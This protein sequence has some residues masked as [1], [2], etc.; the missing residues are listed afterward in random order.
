MRWLLAFALRLF[1][2]ALLIGVPASAQLV[3]PPTDSARESFDN[4][5]VATVSTGAMSVANGN[6]GCIYLQ[7]TGTITLRLPARIITTNLPDNV[8][9][10]YFF[11]I[12]NPSG[13]LP[14]QALTASG[15]NGA[16]SVPGLVARGGVAS[17]ANQPTGTVGPGNVVNGEFRLDKDLA[18]TLLPGQSF[19][20]CVNGASTGVTGATDM[21]A[22]WTVPIEW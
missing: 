3:N 2:V 16:T 18:R 12:A 6:V 15:R 20:N 9:Q 4:G 19:A 14:T 21:V 8:T 13:N 5:R 11:G 1:I 17:V 22:V 7:N 10:P